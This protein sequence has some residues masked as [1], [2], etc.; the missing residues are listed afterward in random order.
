MFWIFQDCISSLP[1]FFFLVDFVKFFRNEDHNFHQ[2]CE[3]K[4]SRVDVLNGHVV[5]ETSE[6]LVRDEKSY[7]ENTLSSVN[8]TYPGNTNEI[9]HKS[10]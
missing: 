4:Y 10:M 1:I 2:E 5:Q 7:Y 8:I 9:K 6:S 3:I